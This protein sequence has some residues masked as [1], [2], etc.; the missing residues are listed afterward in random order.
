MLK[1]RDPFSFWV[2]ERL[3]GRSNEEVL[4]DMT[5]PEIIQ[6]FDGMDLL[7]ALNI[8]IPYAIPIAVGLLTGII[9]LA[10]NA[11]LAKL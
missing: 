6:V 2:E 1:K 11:W 7:I 8:R 5:V 10:I 9:A 3:R 4:R